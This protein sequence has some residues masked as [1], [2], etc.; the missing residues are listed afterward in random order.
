MARK[1][2][3]VVH[4][5]YER[6]SADAYWYESPRFAYFERLGAG[7]AGFVERYPICGRVVR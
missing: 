3:E 1:T 2:L 7:A 5:R 6:R 4:Q